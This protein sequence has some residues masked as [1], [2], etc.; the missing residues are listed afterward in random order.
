MLK[1]Y[2]SY[3]VSYIL[4][5][6]KSQDQIKNIILY[7]SV[8]RDTATDESDIDLFIEV[9]KKTK[10]FERQVSEITNQF[11]ESRESALFKTKGIENEFSIILGT[12]KEWDDLYRS[13]ASTGI[14]LYGPFKGTHLPK[15][16]NLYVIIF[17][18]GIGKNRGSFLNK[19]YGVKIHNKRY[20]GLLEKSE[21]KKLG[22]SCV[23]L[24]IVW[25]SEMFSLIKKHNVN[26]RAIEV[27][28]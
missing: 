5:H 14:V 19:V 25:K 3:F 12:L 27:F 11:Y 16:K 7:G 6:L 21:G 23:M 22:K 8:A 13:I 24:P 4:T 18:D 17:W 2:A 10:L 28:L 1:G 26:A 20:P 9:T 15:S